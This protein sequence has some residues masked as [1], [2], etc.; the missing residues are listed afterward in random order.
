MREVLTDARSGLRVPASARDGGGLR[1]RLPR[2]RVPR[3]HAR[4]RDLELNLANPA[5]SRDRPRTTTGRRASA[6]RRRH[7]TAAATAPR[8]PPTANHRRAHHG[9]VSA[10]DRHRRRDNVR[11]A[12]GGHVAEPRMSVLP[13]PPC[14]RHAPRHPRVRQHPPWAG[15]AAAYRKY[16]AQAHTPPRLRSPADTPTVA[17]TRPALRTTPEPAIMRHVTLTSTGVR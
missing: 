11:P 16:D 10:P 15:I 1:Q 12:G 4:L 13:R 7:R 3:V 9:T 2:Q 6:H 17:T 14:R 5:G 8:V